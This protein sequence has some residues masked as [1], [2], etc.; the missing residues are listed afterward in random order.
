MKVVAREMAGAGFDQTVIMHFNTANKVQRLGGKATGVQPSRG[1]Q[2]QSAALGL[3]GVVANPQQ[4]WTSCIDV[5][6]G[7][8]GVAVH[9]SMKSDSRAV[10][11]RFGPQTAGSGVNA[12]WSHPIETSVPG[13]GPPCGHP[14][15]A[16]SSLLKQLDQVRRPQQRRR[17]SRVQR[18][19][20]PLC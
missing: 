14:C 17:T 20:W 1:Q 16:T 11:L 8:L 15:A 9:W 13:G 6:T 12:P 2:P 7:A 18:G 19:A 3:K 5:P 4:E 10:C